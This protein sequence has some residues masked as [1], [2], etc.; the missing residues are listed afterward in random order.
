MAKLKIDF[1]EVQ[2]A[3][4]DTCRDS[5][6]YF[7]DTETGDV[8][9]LSEDIIRK[10][11]S[12]LYETL[13]E[14]MADYDGVEFDEEIDMADWIEEEVELALDIFLYGGDR[15]VRIPERQSVSGYDAMKEFAE[16]LGDIELKN[17]LLGVLDG[18]GAFRKFKNVLE[19]RPQERK[20]WYKF[21][22][23][24]ARDEIVE[25]LG[26]LGV[27]ENGKAGKECPE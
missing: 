23:K 24:R 16:G 10:A 26:S 27:G 7:L 17:E 5:F 4:E 11:H 22:A 19:P 20:Q 3:M 25:W 14:D 1:D 15:Y 12:V 18:R 13:D 9:I 21:N 6:D 2:K 8:I